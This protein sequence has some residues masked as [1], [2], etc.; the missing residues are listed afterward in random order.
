[1]LQVGFWSALVS[2]NWT[3]GGTGVPDGSQAEPQSMPCQ[4]RAQSRRGIVH[5]GKAREHHQSC[6]LSA[7]P[8][9]GTKGNSVQLQE[10][11]PVL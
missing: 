4:G 9:L 11:S 5:H 3:W 1:M 10:L 8:P 6:K 2:Q 7:G